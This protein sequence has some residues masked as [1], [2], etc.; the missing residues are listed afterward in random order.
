MPISR[1]FPPLKFDAS[2]VLDYVF[3]AGE[4]PS[5]HLDSHCGTTARTRDPTRQGIGHWRDML[6]TRWWGAGR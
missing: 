1:S 5:D 3:P 4:A 2:S 6:G